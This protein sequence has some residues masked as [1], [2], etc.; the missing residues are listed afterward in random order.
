MYQ[1]MSVV[2]EAPYLPYGYEL[3]KPAR[4]GTVGA[5]DPQLFMSPSEFAECLHLGNSIR[6]ISPLTWANWLDQ[7]AATAGVEI[8]RA[9]SRIGDANGA[10]HR[11]SVDVTILG[12]I[13]RFFAEK[14]RAAV[15]WEFYLLSGED[16]A[17]QEAIDH[18]RRAQD[19][20]AVAAKVCQ[21]VYVADITYG[22]HSWLRGRWD[23]RLPAIA[24]DISE[25]VT[26]VAEDQ[27]AGFRDSALGR[28]QV[29]QIQSWSTSQQQACR[30]RPP[31][32]FVHGADIEL[33]CAPFGASQ[34][35]V[36]LHY[37]HVNQSE[38]WQL[39]E[40]QWNEGT[41]A[42]R[43]PGAYTASPFSIQYYFEVQEGTCAGF[44]PGLGED[45]SN[46]PY[47]V[48]VGADSCRKRAAVEP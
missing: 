47:F 23:D 6:R 10:F 39:V 2:H 11:F 7:L 34:H 12:A 8:A 35:G 28:R 25:M 21:D 46:V 15:L 45:L 26:L 40:M 27:L 38:P 4:F 16:R 37:R 42:A 43:I 9:E 18:Y 29:A 33:S 30:H 20:W 19:A 17:A 13:G 3:F 14:I 1:N 41:Y 22:P 36:F 32:G 24:R 48:L 31:D 44:Y 5:S